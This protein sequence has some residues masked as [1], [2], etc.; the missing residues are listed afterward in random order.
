M[1]LYF[2]PDETA[3]ESAERIRLTKQ[4]LAELAARG[5]FSGGKLTAGWGHRVTVRGINMYHDAPGEVFGRC[6]LEQIRDAVRI[7]C[8]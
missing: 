1:Q 8:R 3:A 4:L 6:T 2:S 7:Y 5:L